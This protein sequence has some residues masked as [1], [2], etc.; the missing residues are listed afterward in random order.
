MPDRRSRDQTEPHLPLVRELFF[1]C[2][3]NRVRIQEELEK[4]GIGIAYS[5]L[6][7][8]LRRLGVGVVVKQ[9][10]GE[11]VF[12]P[13][14]EMQHDT[15]PHSF[16]IA[17]RRREGHT[18][19]LVLG[20]SRRHFMQSY[21][22]W[23]RFWCRVFLTDALVYFEG[24]AARCVLDNSSV[25]IVRGTGK[26]A[27]AAPEMQALAT[28]FDFKFFCHEV[29]DANRSGKVERPFLHYERNFL[30]GRS[31][32]SWEHLNAEARAWCERIDRKYRKRLRA[33]PMELFAAE[34]PALRP[35]PSYIPEVYLLE[36]RVVD[37]EG[38][39]HLYGNRYSAPAP[40]LGR[41][42]EVRAYKDRVVIFDGRRQAAEHP[43][44][45]D[46]ADAR[47]AKPEHRIP[48][49]KPGD[50]PRALP[51]EKVLRSAGAA[52][53]RLT[54]LVKAHHDARALRRL[55][56]LYLDYPAEA[57][58][59]AAATALDFGVH[60][61]PRIE[62]LVLRTVQTSYFRIST[63][64]DPDDQLQAG[65]ETDDGRQPRSTAAQPQTRQDSPD[66]RRRDQEG[67][68]G[69]DEL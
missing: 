10:A 65:G 55:Y 26:D 40:L 36:S 3:G 23:N 9:P 14:V 42:V 47:L 52:I 37:L 22:R 5:T 54:E 62:R 51:E 44:A 58:D 20:Y 16:P 41:T 50:P 24:A 13:G 7:A 35:L 68:E 32:T 17:G 45:E 39:I 53:A 30:A 69:Q 67:D 11:Y 29:G 2:Q 33:S 48:R 49:R 8:G 4:R 63:A 27:V 15:S 34:Q 6:T 12:A 43:R 61:I 38:Y 66:S 46:G 28:H 60:D 31:F 56:R 21:P 64:F 18:A 19:S 1:R 57:L 25:I 59:K